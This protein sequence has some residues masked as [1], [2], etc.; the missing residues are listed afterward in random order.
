MSKALIL[1]LLFTACALDHEVPKTN[2]RFV[3]K[4][5]LQVLNCETRRAKLLYCSG[6]PVNWYCGTDYLWLVPT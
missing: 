2:Q 3:E 4:G 1:S 5:Q 6:L